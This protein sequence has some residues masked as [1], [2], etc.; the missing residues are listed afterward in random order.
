VANGGWF[1]IGRA[2]AV[3]TDCMIDEVRGFAKRSK[4][5][6]RASRLL[7]IAA[8]LEGATRENAARIGGMDR[9][10][11]RDWVIRCN[12]LTALGRS[13]NSKVSRRFGPLTAPGPP[14][15]CTDG[16]EETTNQAGSSGAA[17]RSASS[18]IALLSSSMRRS[19]GHLVAA[20]P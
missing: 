18:S 2:I 12:Y 20:A 16:R 8:V 9:Q 11:L 7:A 13:A 6:A 17:S 19:L 4:D 10:T 3:R 15:S 14:T 1:A 5:A